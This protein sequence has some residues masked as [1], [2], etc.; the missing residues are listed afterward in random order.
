MIEVYPLGRLYEEVAFVAYHFQWNQGEILEMPHWV[1][2][3]WCEEIS[4][5]NEELNKEARESSDHGG[6]TIQLDGPGSPFG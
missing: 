6:T 2:Q 5:I 3:R 4:K 1:R